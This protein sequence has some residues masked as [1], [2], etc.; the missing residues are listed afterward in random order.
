MGARTRIY[1]AVSVLIGLAATGDGV[2]FAVGAG[3][4]DFSVIHAAVVFAIGARFFGL[5]Y[6]AVAAGRAPTTRRG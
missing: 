1:V 5:A 6:R 4:S 3:G 2:V